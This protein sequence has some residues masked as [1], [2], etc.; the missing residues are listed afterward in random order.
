MDSNGDCHW[1]DYAQSLAVFAIPGIALAA[2]S[3]LA[4]P[5]FVIFRFCCNTFGGRRR[6]KGKTIKLFLLINP[7]V[8]CVS[9][10]N[11]W[12]GYSKRAIMIT[13]IVVWATTVG[14]M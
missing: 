7:G 6:T 8:C 10:P 12:Q 11:Q 1:A 14:L 4:L 9:K 5:V 13:K 3:I 2:L